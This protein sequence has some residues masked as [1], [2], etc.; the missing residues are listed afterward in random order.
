[1]QLLIPHA[2]LV[3]LAFSAAMGYLA[4]VLLLALG[5]YLGPP[6]AAPSRGPF[7]SRDD[8]GQPD[9]PI[10]SFSTAAVQDYSPME[11]TV[12]WEDPAADLP[13]PGPGTHGGTTDTGPRG[14]LPSDPPA[15]PFLPEDAVPLPADL[16]EFIP[17]MPLRPPVGEMASPT[18]SHGRTPRDASPS[19]LPEE[20]D[21]LSTDGLVHDRLEEPQTVKEVRL[22]IR[23]REEVAPHKRKR[24]KCAFPALEP[25]SSSAPGLY[26]SGSL[27]CLDYAG[28]ETYFEGLG[29]DASIKNLTRASQ[30]SCQSRLAAL[31]ADVECLDSDP[32]AYCFNAEEDPGI[33]PM[34][35]EDFGV[36]ADTLADLR[37]WAKN[38]AKQTSKVDSPRRSARRAPDD[39]GPEGLE[40]TSWWELQYG[41]RSWAGELTPAQ[42]REWRDDGPPP[43]MARFK[44]ARVHG[45]GLDIPAPPIH[46]NLDVRAY[47]CGSPPDIVPQVAE[48]EEDFCSHT[49]YQQDLVIKENVTMKVLQKSRDRHAYTLHCSVS[50]STIPSGCGFLSH[51][52]LLHSYLA[53]DRREDI[54]TSECYDMFRNQTF[55]DERGIVHNL[56]LG[57]VNTIHT[58]TAGRVQEDG[59][60]VTGEALLEGVWKTGVVVST[61]RK[62]KIVRR[63]ATMKE[64]GT[65]LVPSLQKRLPCHRLSGGCITAMGTFKWSAQE[66]VDQCPYYQLRQ[67]TGSLVADKSGHTLFVSKEGALVRLFLRSPVSACGSVLHRTNFA[68]LYLTEDLRNL[69]FMRQLPQAEYDISTYVAQADSWED[70]HI[71]AWMRKELQSALRYECRRRIQRDRVTQAQL[72]AARTTSATMRDAV[73]LGNAVFALPAGDVFYRFTCRPIRVE[74]V[75]VNKCYDALPVRLSEQDYRIYS[76]TRGLHVPQDE[77]QLFVAPGNHI[78]EPVGVPTLCAN[79]TPPIFRGMDGQY[80][81]AN[82]EVSVVPTP[83]PL[84]LSH[85]DFT[86]PEFYAPDYQ[87]GQLAH[88][89]DLAQEFEARVHEERYVDDFTH[90]VALRAR[91]RGFKASSQTPD[92][93][94]DLFGDL[95]LTAHYG[96]FWGNVAYLL[97]GALAILL[98]ILL[99]RV[100]FW[101]LVSISRSR[102]EPLLRREP[103]LLPALAH[104]W[105]EVKDLW[106]RPGDARPGYHQVSQRAPSPPPAYAP[107]NNNPAEASAPPDPSQRPLPSR[108]GSP[109]PSSPPPRPRPSTL[110][111]EAAKEALA[112]IE[113]HEAAER[114]ERTRQGRLLSM[115]NLD[116]DCLITSFLQQPNLTSEISFAAVALSD[117]IQDLHDELAEYGVSPALHVSERLQKRNAQIREALDRLKDKARRAPELPFPMSPPR[118]ERAIDVTEDAPLMPPL[119]VRPM[120][121]PVGRGRGLGPPLPPSPRPGSADQPARPGSALRP[122]IGQGP[123]P[124]RGSAPSLSSVLTPEMLRRRAEE[125]RT[126]GKEGGQGPDQAP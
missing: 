9:E 120:G 99:F 1:M 103:P 122:P 116:L 46:H 84:H 114:K 112:E 2:Q 18:G 97:L 78:L 82:P 113:A 6:C 125:I 8:P 126:R 25:V 85:Q 96:P 68:N 39:A 65:V 41:N 111:V 34:A 81:L 56:T 75:S 54:T 105:P 27:I 95:S 69:K 16:G 83:G 106:I 71:K 7:P 118:R 55:R 87:E 42:Q 89:L 61:H 86:E 119:P 40:K 50:R 36:T 62:I 24:K 88:N 35:I 101:V 11:G 32:P 59:T 80:I 14:S 72:N 98:G 110:A 51:Q 10:P 77:F 123:L 37:E 4:L 12:P 67:T 19:L 121:Q 70:G 33:D 30:A 49:L 124:E 57:V 53:L 100:A 22:Q 73:H 109:R 107:A 76:E 117:Q 13:S 52:W 29:C 94:T 26:R 23:G 60:C 45:D 17:G 93:T 20:S 66:V 92:L 5:G 47:D 31:G 44:R 3:R 115:N 102:P 74:A 28:V 43:M 64:D 63:V 15:P 79:L 38:W 90:N 91:D 58:P 48:D 21:T 104:W 108:P